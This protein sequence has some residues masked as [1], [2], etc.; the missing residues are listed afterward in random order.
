[1]QDQLSASIATVI[2]VVTRTITVRNMTT[3]VY[4]YRNNMNIPIHLQFFRSYRQVAFLP[5]R[6]GLQV[7]G[8]CETKLANVFSENDFGML[9]LFDQFAKSNIAPFMIWLI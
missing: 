4:D 5:N 2:T 7:N 3:I 9:S 8:K 1:M 6:L